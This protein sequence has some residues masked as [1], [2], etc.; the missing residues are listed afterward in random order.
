MSD[1]KPEFNYD[2]L[3]PERWLHAEDLAGMNVTLTM[4]AAYEEVLR[5]PD[6]SNDRCG[7]LSFEKTKREYV[8][9]KTNAMVLRELWGKKSGGWVG[10]QITIAPVP[11]PSG[12]SRSG[13]KILFIGSPDL[14]KDT[15]VNQPQNKTRIIKKTQPSENRVQEAIA[16]APP[17]HD[18]VSEAPEDAEPLTRTEGE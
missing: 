12:K 6:G 7:I 5:L 13:K 11:D 10:H 1:E 9:N 4:S 16:A 14:A 17:E 18:P 3:F 8:L 15:K 2:D